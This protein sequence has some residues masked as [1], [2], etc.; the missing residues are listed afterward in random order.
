MGLSSLILHCEQEAIGSLLY[1]RRVAIEKLAS[2]I[3]ERHSPRAMEY[4]LN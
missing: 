3:R 2:F 1:L 4:P